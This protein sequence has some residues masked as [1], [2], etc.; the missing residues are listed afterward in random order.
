M[1][2]HYG[3]GAS[4]ARSGG[5]P[6]SGSPLTR[7]MLRELGPG[8]RGALDDSPLMDIIKALPAQ[9][10]SRWHQI[11]PIPPTVRAAPTAPAPQQAGFQDQL[12]QMLQNPEFMQGL[13]AL[14]QPQAQ[15]QWFP[16]P[17]TAFPVFGQFPSIPGGLFG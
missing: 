3:L 15:P 17:P 8:V 2:F 11:S 9:N 1:P 6:G 13:G 7:A 5:G 14:L 16:M 10:P 12:L 4:L